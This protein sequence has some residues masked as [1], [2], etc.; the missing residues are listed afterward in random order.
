MNRVHVGKGSLFST[1]LVAKAVCCRESRYSHATL[2]FWATFIYTKKFEGKNRKKCDKWHLYKVFLST[3]KAK[4][5]M[6]KELAIYRQST[7]GKEDAFPWQ[8]SK[9]QM[10]FFGWLQ[11]TKGSGGIFFPLPP[12]LAIAF[13]VFSAQFRPFSPPF[14]LLFPRSERRRNIIYGIARSFHVGVEEERMVG[15]SLR[16]FSSASSR[17]FPFLSTGW[18]VGPRAQCL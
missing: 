5:L 2:L 15:G 3:K 12:F 8:S 18:L 6:E 13:L 7:D 17:V 14:S 1:W 16:W 9:D 11:T 4:V 10:V